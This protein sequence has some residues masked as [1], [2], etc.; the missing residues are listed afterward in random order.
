MREDEASPPP[1]CPS[2][3]SLSLSPFFSFVSLYPLGDIARKLLIFQYLF[4]NYSFLSD[5]VKTDS[6]QNSY[7]LEDGN[8]RKEETSRTSAVVGE[9]GPDIRQDADV[10]SDP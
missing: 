4:E 5:R 2:F 10:E 8:D 9:T 3:F 6:F 1:S 7:N